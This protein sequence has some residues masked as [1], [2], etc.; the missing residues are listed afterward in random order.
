MPLAGFAFGLAAFAAIGLP[1]FANF[2]GEVLIFFGAFSREANMSHFQIYQVA[3][4][5]AVWGVVIS[6][7]YMLR[8]YR[9]VFMGSMDA[10]W[11]T[12]PDLRG[13]LRWPIIL[14]VAGL[15]WV[16]FFPQSFVRIITPPFRS[17]FAA[18]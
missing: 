8:A 2:A 14:L 10:K 5:L 18:K 6:A 17:Y 15:L 4:V 12:L 16:G 1:G 11:N 3:T 7:V 13:T 9:A